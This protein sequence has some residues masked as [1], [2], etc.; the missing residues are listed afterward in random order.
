MKKVSFKNAEADD[1]N[2]VFTYL[3]ILIHIIAVLIYRLDN[4]RHQLFKM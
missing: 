3:S 4:S 1:I 2:E